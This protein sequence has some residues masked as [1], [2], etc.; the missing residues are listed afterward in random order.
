MIDRIKS[1]LGSSGVEI[2]V[3]DPDISGFIDRAV[4]KIKTHIQDTEFID[5]QV[6]DEIDLSDDNVEGVV[7]VFNNRST[8]STKN[9]LSPFYHR[10][11][12]DMSK[13]ENL[14][15]P[16]QMSEMEEII[17]RNF[18][19]DDTEKKLYLDGYY[20]GSITI[21]VLKDVTLETL[22]NEGD[23]DWVFEYAKALTMEA[24]ANIRGKF[25]VDSTPYSTDADSMRQRAQSRIDS[26]EKELEEKGYFY[27]TR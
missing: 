5:K 3:D 2:E 13:R 14:L 9:K 4:R 18:R 11:Y 6:N 24:L 21:E 15:M 25:D 16:Y 17:D 8:I 27:M 23:V 20:E 19:F 12:A 7:R 22:K 26:L 10:N 1:E